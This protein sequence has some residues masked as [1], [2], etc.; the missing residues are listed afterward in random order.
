MS[1]L[2]EIIKRDDIDLDVTITDTDGNAIDLTN[3]TVIFTMKE[4]MFD[5]D[6]VIQKRITSHTDPT[7]GKTRVVLDHDD[8][9]VTPKYYFFD[10]QVV[11]ST[12]KVTSIPRGQV[13]V[14]QDIT[15][16]AS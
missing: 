14:M 2:L 10:L 5:E 13:R 7:E 12:G 3:K 6:Y 1:D 4:N 9:N 15:A 16:E 11:S 8:T